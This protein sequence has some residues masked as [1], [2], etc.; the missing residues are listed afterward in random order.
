MVRFVGS[1]ALPSIAVAPAP[2]KLEA[3]AALIT[4]AKEGKV[5]RLRERASTR[6]E[7]ARLQEAV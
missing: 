3:P 1:F 4:P 5:I 2:V 7:K 6:R